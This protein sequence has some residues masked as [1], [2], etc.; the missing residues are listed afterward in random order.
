LA[1]SGV[2]KSLP[3]GKVWFGIPVQDAKDKMEELVWVKR[4]PELWDRMRGD[5]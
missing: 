4:I 1:K 3:G 5:Y 2:G